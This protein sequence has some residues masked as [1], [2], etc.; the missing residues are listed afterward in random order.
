MENRGQTRD[1]EIWPNSSNHLKA[2]LPAPDAIIPRQWTPEELDFVLGRHRVELTDLLFSAARMTISRTQQQ[3]TQAAA[4]PA[5][6]STA[7]SS[8]AVPD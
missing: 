4:V 1:L 7:S 6:Q 3:L 5:L 8:A 2:Y